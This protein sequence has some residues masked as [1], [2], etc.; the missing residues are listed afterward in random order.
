MWASRNRD[1]IMMMWGLRNR[2]PADGFRT[3]IRAGMFL[4]RWLLALIFFFL[5]R[6]RWPCR[7]GFGNWYSELLFSMTMTMLKSRFVHLGIDFL[8][9]RFSMSILKSRFRVFGIDF[10]LLGFSKSRLRALGIDFPVLG[11]SK[12]WFRVFTIDIPV[13]R[14]SKS[15]FRFFGIDLPALGFSKSRFTVFGIDFAV[16]RFSK[17]RYRVFTIDLPVS[18][19]D[20]LIWIFFPLIWKIGF[21]DSADGFR[22]RESFRDRFY[23]CE[24]FEI[25]I[26]GFWDRFSCN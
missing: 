24:V 23:W 12:S 17:S 14:V 18:V 16:F 7:C 25:T 10:P 13:L 21:L 1:S 26:L 9:Y 11:L 8:V 22:N 2:D 4:I 19:I 20:F 5:K 6:C 3:R 15:R